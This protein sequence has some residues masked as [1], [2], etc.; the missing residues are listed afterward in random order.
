MRHIAHSNLVWLVRIHLGLLHQVLD[1][2]EVAIL[3]GNEERSSPVLDG[4]RFDKQK[5]T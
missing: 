2:L 3:G 4:T 1:H 5:S